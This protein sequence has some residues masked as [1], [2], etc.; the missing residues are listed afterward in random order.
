MKFSA[1]RKIKSI[2]S[3]IISDIV[4]WLALLLV[5]AGIVYYIFAILPVQRGQQ[6]TLQ[7][8]DASAIIE[9]SSV[10]MMGLEV[11]HVNHIELKKGHVDISIITE[12]GMPEIPE[13]TEFTILFSGLGGSQSIEA[14]L[15]NMD[16]PKAP[17]GS[18]KSLMPGTTSGGYLVSE[19][20]RLKQVLDTN[21]VVA[22][23]LQQG[24]ENIT[25]FFGH[26]RS[27]VPVLQ[28]NIKVLKKWSTD[29]SIVAN[30]LANQSA[31]FSK[32]FSSNTYSGLNTVKEINSRVA[33]VAD[34]TEPQRLRGKIRRLLPS[35]EGSRMKCNGDTCYSVGKSKPLL[36]WNGKP[37]QRLY[38]AQATTVQS[39]KWLSDWELAQTH[40]LSQ[41]NYVNDLLEIHPLEPQLK[42]TRLKIQELNT[43]FPDWNVKLDAL[44]AKMQ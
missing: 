22:R 41:L 23:A 10:H 32:D 3:A 31:K 9:G 2:D 18:T 42:N 40:M 14:I 29:S 28:S 6:I 26:K 25:D 17:M 34:A 30:R 16:V 24:S 43:Q 7:F 5:A 36:V 37:R 27:S 19:P 8:Q 38:Q 4:L 20:I 1:L 21:I 44:K 39:V 35:L 15:P 12:P 33:K 11:G 13:G